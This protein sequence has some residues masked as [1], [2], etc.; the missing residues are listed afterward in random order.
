MSPVEL[1]GLVDGIRLAVVWFGDP[2]DPIAVAG[3]NLGRPVRAHGVDDQVVEVGV[4]LRQDEVDAS[5]RCG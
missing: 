5:R 2:P 3:E 1:D 4:L